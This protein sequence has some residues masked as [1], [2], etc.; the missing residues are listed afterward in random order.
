MTRR[1]LTDGDVDCRTCG[2]CCV[3]PQDTPYGW[4][5]VSTDDADRMSTRVRLKLVNT[6]G[7]WQF[8]ECR[9]S[10]PTTWS[11]EL[12]VA[13]CSFLRGTPGKRCSCGIYETRPDVCRKLRPGSRACRESREMLGLP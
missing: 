6:G 3:S 4:A 1:A 7:G 9:L 2:A 10:T 5:D 8:N 11:D 12:N 13:P